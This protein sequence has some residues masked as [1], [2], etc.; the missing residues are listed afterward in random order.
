MRKLSESFQWLLVCGWIFLWGFI[1]GGFLLS[2]EKTVEYR[3]NHYFT[4][5]EQFNNSPVT[6][7]PGD[8]LWVKRSEEPV[9]LKN[10]EIYSYTH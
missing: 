8:R 1:L 5:L 10:V 4:S 6:F 7:K 9:L 3:D 2:G